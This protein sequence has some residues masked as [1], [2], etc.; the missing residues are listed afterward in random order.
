MIRAWSITALIVVLTIFW[1]V[2]LVPIAGLIDMTRIRSVFPGLAD[3]LEAH[4][5]AESLVQTQLPI[6]ITSLLNVLVPYFYWCMFFEQRISRSTANMFIR[7]L[8]PSRH[9]LSWGDGTF[10]HL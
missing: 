8:D 1:S 2:V 9:D 3:A 7:A 5:I 6:L 4:P 10:R